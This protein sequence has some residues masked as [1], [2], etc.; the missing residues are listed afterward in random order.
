MA[1]TSHDIISKN[2]VSRH[3]F[4]MTADL[5]EIILECLGTKNIS[6]TS[7]GIVAD[8]I[9]VYSSSF[10]DE[11]KITDQVLN[12]SGVNPFTQNTTQQII[13]ANISKLKLIRLGES[14][15]DISLSINFQS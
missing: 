12:E 10:D 6:I 2:N 13:N 9:T 3:T 14:D 7:S 15:G 5:D 4:I 1:I 8:Q 11:S